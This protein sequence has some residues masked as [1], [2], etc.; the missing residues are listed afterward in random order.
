M[1]AEWLWVDLQ[2]VI[3]GNGD[4]IRCMWRGYADSFRNVMGGR[5]ERSGIVMDEIADDSARLIGGIASRK[6]GIW[7]CNAGEKVGIG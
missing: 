6:V 7:W 5:A 1:K 3:D 4:G 2:I